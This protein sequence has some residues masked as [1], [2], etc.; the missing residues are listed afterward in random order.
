MNMWCSNRK[1]EA[2]TLALIICTFCAPALA[3]ESDYRIQSLNAEQ[4]GFTISAYQNEFKWRHQNN[5]YGTPVA[6][7]TTHGDDT[8]S[9][10]KDDAGEALE[11]E[12]Q[13]SF[14][15]DDE[16]FVDKIMGKI[17]Y[18]NTLKA[19]WNFIDGDTDVMVEGLRVDRGNKGLVY[20]TNYMPF[21]GNVDGMQFKA[22][23]GEDMELIY[24][25]DTLPLVGRVEGMRFKSSVGDD[26]QVSLRYSMK[27]KPEWLR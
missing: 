19:T 1:F 11:Q 24:E 5:D 13:A 17:P 8:L 22:E 21:A 2:F 23:M 27:L 16:D 9:L 3:D 10:S 6:P 14:K 12:S 4:G 7:A 20:K 18:S 15:E 25:S 26:A